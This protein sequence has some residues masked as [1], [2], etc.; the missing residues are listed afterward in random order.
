MDTAAV[1]LRSGEEMLLRVMEPPL[2]Q[3]SE[4]LEKRELVKWIWP[5][6]RDDILEG[7]MKKWLFTPYALGELDGE[8]V[9][10]MAYYTP[11]DTRDVGLIEFVETREEHRGKG[12]ASALL[13]ELV[14]RFTAEGGQ[15]LLLCTGNPIAG[16][17][18]ENYGF[19]YTIG[20]GMRYLAPGAED[21]SESYLAFSGGARIRDAT[22][23]DLPRTS[24]LYNH[25]EP[26]WLVK[27]YLS[28]VFG[29][30]RYERHFVRLMERIGDGNGAYLVLES[31]QK[32]VVGAAAFER[33]GTYYEQHAAVLSFRVCPA[34]FSQARELLDAAASR[35]AELSIGLLQ[36]HVADR[37]E[38]QKALVL[39]AGFTEEARLRNRL[40]D[41]DQ[42]IDMLIYARDLGVDSQP[43]RAKGDYYGGRLTWMEE[44]VAAGK[45]GPAS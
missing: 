15:A 45:A 32:R 5:Q 30:T 33:L 40:R 22:W 25:P 18:Y 38:E 20:D 11:A 19:W 36:V 12:I 43:R 16:R 37:D 23:G 28:E 26:A 31:P 13:A 7:R 3:Y 1:E 17:L 35:A 39:S 24:V 27:D 8:L 44:R 10:S 9:A 4:K 2:T 6:I 34:Y 41:G 14:R 42:W 29:D 21:F